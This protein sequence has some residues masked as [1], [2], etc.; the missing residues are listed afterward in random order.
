M[1]GTSPWVVNVNAS[2]QHPTSGTTL[3]L[4]YNVY[5]PRISEV[6]IQGLPDVYEQPFHRL[7]LA[8]YQ[9]FSH[10]ISL[11]VSA[12]NLLN[13]FIHLTQGPVTVLRYRPGAQLTAQ[14]VW[15]Y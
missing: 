8:L 2:W 6:G 9:Q 12:Q 7:D 1:Q 11:K 13:S 5:G 14:L 4:L 15:A 10:G 3:S